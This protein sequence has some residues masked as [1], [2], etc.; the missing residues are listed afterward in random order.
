MSYLTTG[1]PITD[2]STSNMRACIGQKVEYLRSR[3]I[4]KSG[5]GY[6]F[7]HIGVITEVLRRQVSI[8]GE[9]MRI[10]EIVEINII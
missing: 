9:W 7:P 5:R 2:R 4:D 10:S 3:D 1:V 6:F 8:S